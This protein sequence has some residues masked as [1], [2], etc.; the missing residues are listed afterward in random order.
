MQRDEVIPIL[1]FGAQYAQLIA[2]RVR[3]KGV[4]SELVRPDISVADLKKMRPKGLILSGGPSSVY[5]LGAPKCDPAIFELGVP[6]LGICYG[7]QLGAELLGGKVKPAKAREFGR[8]K[9]TVVSDDPFVKG[10]PRE[11]TV[12]MSHGDQVHDLPADFLP[13]A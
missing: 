7:M 1:D 11:T 9:L 3:E 12:W 10:L 4:Y 8:A 2:R 5:D 13:L 6:V